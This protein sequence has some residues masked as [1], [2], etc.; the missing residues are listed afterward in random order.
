MRKGPEQAF[1]FIRYM[2]GQQV[3]EKMFNANQTTIC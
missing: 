2:N 1:F 3:C